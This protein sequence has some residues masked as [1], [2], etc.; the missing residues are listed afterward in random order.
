MLDLR[1]ETCGT[2]SGS[3]PKTTKI[4][5]PSAWTESMYA[6]LA[7]SWQ[8]LEVE[9]AESDRLPLGGVEVNPAAGDMSDAEPVVPLVADESALRLQHLRFRV[10]EHLD[11]LQSKVA[12]Q[13]QR[14]SEGLQREL[15]RF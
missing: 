9:L 1:K 14:P 3:A 4:W 5:Y 15:P 6:L 2:G 8:I 12:V 10:F 11:S 7:G 13:L